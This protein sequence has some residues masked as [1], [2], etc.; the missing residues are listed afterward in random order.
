MG[1]YTQFGLGALGAGLGFLKSGGPVQKFANGG[2]S[3]D[4]VPALLMGGEFVMR[5]EAVN[6]YGKRFFDELNNGRIKKFANGG[7]AG[8]PNNSETISNYS[9]VSNVNVTVN[10][11]KDSVSSEVSQDNTQRGQEDEAL[12]A[13]DLADKVKSQVMRVIT[14]QQRPGGLLSSA[15]YK[16][17]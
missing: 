13:K 4:N 9:P 14:E 15:V 3:E 16:K 7:Q 12:K 17:L 8:S 6:L 11:T 5:K 1:A 2:S 10:V